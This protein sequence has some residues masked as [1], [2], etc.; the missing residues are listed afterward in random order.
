MRPSLFLF[1]FALG[2][3]ASTAVVPPPPPPPAVRVEAV[4]NPVPVVIET[5]PAEAVAAEPPPTPRMRITERSIYEQDRVAVWT[6][7]SGLTVVYAWDDGAAQYTSLM[8]YPGESTLPE[9]GLSFGL[10]RTVLVYKKQRLDDALE[11]VTQI[12]RRVRPDETIVLLHG[13]IGPEWV[14]PAM[15]STLGTVPHW[16]RLDPRAPPALRGADVEWADWPSLAVAARLVRE[17]DSLGTVRVDPSVGRALVTGT[18]GAPV[19]D[20]SDNQ[21]RQERADAVDAARSPEGLLTVLDALFQLDGRFRPARPVSEARAFADRIERAPP[22]RVKAML[23][24]LA[25]TA[26]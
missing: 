24:R 9:S 18:K 22:D 19:L 21:I 13:P 15:A 8:S 20:P 26:R 16:V 25:R 6:L 5:Q 10:D 23:S 3:C 12:A 2:G 4:P 7:D 11:Q 17:R 14:E 1:A